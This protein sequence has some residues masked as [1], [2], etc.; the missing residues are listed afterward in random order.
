MTGTGGGHIASDC[1]TGYG[2]D[3]VTDCAEEAEAICIPKVYGIDLRSC[4]V[5]IEGGGVWSGV[6]SAALPKPEDK[7]ACFFIL[8]PKSRE[9]IVSHCTSS[10]DADEV[11]VPDIVREN[12]PDAAFFSASRNLLGRSGTTLGGG[13]GGLRWDLDLNHVEDQVEPGRTESGGDC[14]GVI[15]FA[16]WPKSEGI[17]AAALVAVIRVSI[18]PGG[19]GGG[20]GAR[21][22]RLDDFCTGLDRRCK[23]STD[24]TACDTLL[25]FLSATLHDRDNSGAPSV[26]SDTLCRTGSGTL[27]QISSMS[28][29]IHSMEG[30]GGAV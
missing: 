4:V 24:L 9:G 21:V 5:A 16:E 6:F 13:T 18:L 3:E 22:R 28:I 25:S 30:E 23:E 1:D 27:S 11:V 14:I 12:G 26:S 17:L 29:E 7:D 15:S 20:G 19:G 10:R 2:T 8:D